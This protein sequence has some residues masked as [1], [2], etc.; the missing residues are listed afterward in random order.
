MTNCLHG[1][2]GVRLLIIKLEPTL[3]IPHSV[4]NN[5][6]TIVYKFPDLAL[7]V[8]INA[9]LLGDLAGMPGADSRFYNRWG[10]RGLLRFCKV[11]TYERQM[12]TKRSSMEGKGLGKN[13]K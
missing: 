8:C 12:Y 9:L 5:V 6:K 4:V 13:V 11:L 1:L 2:K 10:K 7:I 3:S